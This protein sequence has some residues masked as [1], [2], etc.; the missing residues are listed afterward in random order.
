MLEVTK[1]EITSTCNWLQ[2]NFFIPFFFT[3]SS[4]A[5]TTPTPAAVC[6]TSLSAILEAPTTPRSVTPAAATGWSLGAVGGLGQQGEREPCMAPTRLSETSVASTQVIVSPCIPSRT[7]CSRR[8]SS[9]CPLP[10]RC[11]RR[12]RIFRRT[13]ARLPPGVASVT[14]TAA[15]A[16][17]AP[18]WRRAWGAWGAWAWAEERPEAATSS[19]VKVIWKA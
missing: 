16:V 6:S 7:P 4:R 11:R 10:C 13:A 1:H 3:L 14:T 17:T 18:G 5:S 15:Q 2:R 12:R 8:S 19:A 9:R